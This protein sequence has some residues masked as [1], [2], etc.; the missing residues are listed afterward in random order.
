MDGISWDRATRGCGRDRCRDYLSFSSRRE[1]G[2]AALSAGGLL[3]T[4]GENL[5]GRGW[6]AVAGFLFPFVSFF[7]E[8]EI[9]GVGRGSGESFK[10]LR[11]E[12]GATLFSFLF[13]RGVF[14]NHLPCG[15]Q[16]PT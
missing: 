10:G 6:S 8:E 2:K 13:P 3:G 16:R 4:P 7:H 12:K 11:K 15:N 14:F 9:R 5:F 1:E